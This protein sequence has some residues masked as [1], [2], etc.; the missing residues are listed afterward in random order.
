MYAKLFT[1]AVFSTGLLATI[2]SK[3]EVTQKVARGGGS[4]ESVTR[5]RTFLDEI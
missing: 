1:L 4:N 3:N 5:F 2:H